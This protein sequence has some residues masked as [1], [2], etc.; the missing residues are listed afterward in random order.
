MP[1]ILIADD[2]EFMRKMLKDILKKGGYGEFL[3]AGDGNKAVELIQSENPDLLI[4]DIIMPELDGIGVLEKIDPKKT[5][6]L[7]VSA[8]GQ[9]QMIKK[10][11]ELGAIGYVVKPFEEEKVL[12]GV[13][14]ALGV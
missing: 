1:K 10:A 5:P 8:V 14:K 9:E 13:R 7:V 4:L 12:E 2:S 11:T 6:V 3:E